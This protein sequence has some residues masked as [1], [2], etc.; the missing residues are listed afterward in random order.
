MNNPVPAGVPLETE[1]VSRVTVSPVEAVP[2]TT[3]SAWAGCKVKG[4]RRAITKLINLNL[5]INFYL[6][7]V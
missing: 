6:S 3:I 5:L 7:N 4:A 1:S 2:R